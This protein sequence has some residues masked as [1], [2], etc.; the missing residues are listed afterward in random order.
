M[1]VNSLKKIQAEAEIVKAFDIWRKRSVID[2]ELDL[3]GLE[4]Y[5]IDIS[6]IRKP[7]MKPSETE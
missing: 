3:S 4:R 6:K 2:W 5:G 7:L 1:K